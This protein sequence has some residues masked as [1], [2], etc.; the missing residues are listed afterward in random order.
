MEYISLHGYIRNTPLD[1]EVHAEHQL[2][3]DRSTCPEEKNI[4]NNAKLGRMKELGGKT[5]VLAGLNL[6]SACG[7]TEAGVQFPQG[8][9]SES[10][11]KHL[12]LTVKQLIYGSL[13]GMRIRQSSPQLYIPR[14][15]ARVPWKVQRL[16]A[17]VWGVWSDPR[18]GAAVDCRELLRGG[19][20]G[21]CDGKCLWRKARQPW[22]QGDTAESHVGGGAITIAFLSPQASI[23]S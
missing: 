14:K 5:G 7:G 18:A 23:G 19:E 15:G 6:P 1:T 10:E 3:A 8:Q 21:D 17:G 4:W 2:R 16:G 9:L 22:K 12:R 11:E 20:G 13:N